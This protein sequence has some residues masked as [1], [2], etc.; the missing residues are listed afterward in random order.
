M[1]AA[2]TILSKFVNPT[3][4]SYRLRSLTNDSNCGS[5]ARPIDDDEED[6]IQYDSCLVWYHFRCVS[7]KQRPKT[8][9]WFC[10]PCY[11]SVSS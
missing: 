11:Q 6:S 1:L 10:R 5:C 8:T 2:A 9:V 3:N 4:H 7:L